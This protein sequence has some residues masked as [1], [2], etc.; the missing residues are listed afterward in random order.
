MKNLFVFKI[1]IRLILFE[2]KLK[3]ARPDSR[4]NDTTKQVSKR[5]R[6]NSMQL[7]RNMQW[8]SECVNGHCRQPPPATFPHLYFVKLLSLSLA[9]FLALRYFPALFSLNKQERDM[10]CLFP[11]K[12]YYCPCE[13]YP[14]LLPR[15]SQ[16]LQAS[17]HYLPSKLAA[18][19]V[20]I[21]G[22][23]EVRLNGALSGDFDPRFLDR[24]FLLNHFI[25]IHTRILLGT[26]AQLCLSDISNIQMYRKICLI[27][28]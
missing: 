28:F 16:R 10:D 26:Y 21:R 25:Y 27:N 8:Q 14:S 20:K 1:R 6:V 18:K 9:R 4:V 17:R 15:T 23:F 13:I 3:D 24:V 11:L 5:P 2:P 22:E 7:K 12:T 19:Q